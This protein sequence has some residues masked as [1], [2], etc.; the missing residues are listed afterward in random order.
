MKVIYNLS[1]ITKS[2]IIIAY[3]DQNALGYIYTEGN[4]WCFCNG[5]DDTNTIMMRDSLEEMMDA[6]DDVVGNSCVY[7]WIE[8]K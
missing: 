1:D 6:I 5:L 7:K 8:F 2:G 4:N 3:N